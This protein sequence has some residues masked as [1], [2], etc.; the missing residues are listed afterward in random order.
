MEILSRRAHVNLTS[1]SLEL[2]VEAVIFIFLDRPRGFKNVYLAVCEFWS[3][4]NV[5]GLSQ[6]KIIYFCEE[7]EIE[8]LSQLAKNIDG[9]NLASD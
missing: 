4:L 7:N 6:Y 9:G 3:R 8:P 2:G 5:Q 1:W